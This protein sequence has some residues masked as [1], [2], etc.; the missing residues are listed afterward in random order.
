MS[1]TVG[2]FVEIGD[3][4]IFPFQVDG[5]RCETPGRPYLVGWNRDRG[6]AIVTRPD[7]GNWA[8]PHCA[9]TNALRWTAR[10]IRGAD[11]LMAGDTRLNFLTLTFRGRLSPAESRARWRACWP[12][13]RARMVRAQAEKIEYMYVHEQ[14]Q[15][16]VLH[17]HFI[18]SG[19]WKKRFFKDI[20]PVVGFGYM[21]DISEVENAIDAGGYVAKYLAKQLGELCWPK[22]WRRITTSQGWPA[23]PPAEKAEGWDWLATKNVVELRAE[24]EGLS[25]LGYRIEILDD[26]EFLE[27][28]VL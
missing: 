13:L 17:I 4:K 7:C 22:G 11:Q 15:S 19:Y 8:C 28:L 6:K 27:G 2:D 5:T 26:K 3:L 23:L 1:E 21:N 24:I 20:P 12:K 16:G 14:H 25:M 10:A 9:Q 18:L